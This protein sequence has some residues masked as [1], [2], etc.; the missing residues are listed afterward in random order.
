MALL[1]YFTQGGSSLWL[2]EFVVLT[3]GEIYKMINMYPTWYK[4]LHYTQI[5]TALFL[6]SAFT[7]QARGEPGKAKSH[8]YGLCW[9]FTIIFPNSCILHTKWSFHCHHYDPLAQKVLSSVVECMHIEGK[10]ILCHKHI[11]EPSTD[12]SLSKCISEK[13][14]LP[15]SSKVRPMVFALYCTTSLSISMSLFVARELV[16]FPYCHINRAYYCAQDC[17]PTQ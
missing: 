9:H 11:L 15:N 16:S 17:A 10:Y 6:Q 3:T 2:P 13:L 12:N 7:L 4:Q 8:H 1:V 14:T 5:N